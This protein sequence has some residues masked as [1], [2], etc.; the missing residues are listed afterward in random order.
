MFSLRSLRSISRK[1]PCLPRRVG[2]VGLLGVRAK[3]SLF[4]PRELRKFEV[5]DA[6]GNASCNQISGSKK[7]LAPCDIGA[8]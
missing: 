4:S 6:F 2:L 1:P 8:L 3:H 7:E 5:S